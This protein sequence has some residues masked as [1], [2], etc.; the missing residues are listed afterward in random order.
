MM[1]LDNDDED[2]DDDESKNEETA[3]DQPAKK[4]TKTN[5]SNNQL[6]KFLSIYHVKFDWV[7]LIGWVDG[8]MDAWLVC[9]LVA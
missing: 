2:G 4:L 7:F 9:W 1:L 3:R 5:L 6:L 8:W